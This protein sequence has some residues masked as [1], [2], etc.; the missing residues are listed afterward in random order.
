MYGPVD[1]FSKDLVIK[2]PARLWGA[3]ENVGTLF[4]STVL[5]PTI[6]ARVFGDSDV[7]LVINGRNGDRITYANVALTKLADL[8][9][10]VDEN[11][12]AADVEFTALLANS[13]EP[14]ADG[15]YFTMLA[16]QTFTETTFAKTNFKRVRCTAAWGSKTG[17]TSFIGKE[18]FNITW[19]LDLK[20]MSVD[21]YGTVDYTVA[22]MTAGC[23]CIPIGPTPLQ[24]EAQSKLGG[25]GTGNSIA[26]GALLSGNA[27]DLT[28]TGTG[29]SVVLK[30]AGL[31]D[32]GYV[33]GVE[34][35]RNG[36]LAWETTRGFTAG[37][38]NAVST[39]S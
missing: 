7:P 25:T 12:F 13:T 3:Y 31:T 26:H 2:I 20:P 17:F 38:P 24:I 39:M 18:G 8:R 37:V 15:A 19:N 34:K 33:F 23:R 32:S 30:N 16:S 35:L 36:E 27:A 4:P 22:G 9:L 21:G 28:I 11:I 5:N 6:G 1:K 10:G 29:L 14:D